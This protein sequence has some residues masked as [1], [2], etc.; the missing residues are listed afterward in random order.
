MTERISPELSLRLELLKCR[1]QQ[2]VLDRRYRQNDRKNRDF[3]DLYIT[4][5]DVLELLENKKRKTRK[6]DAYEYEKIDARGMELREKIK[7][8]PK[9]DS[10]FSLLRY[11]FGLSEQEAF[12]CLFISAPDL[13]PDFDIIVAFLQDNLHL[14]RPSVSL[15]TELFFDAEL[16][17]ASEIRHILG[18]KGTLCSKG[19]IY[20]DE[21]SV[22]D[23]LSFFN[24]RLI[25]SLSLID[26]WLNNILLSAN[27]DAFAELLAPKHT[28]FEG[29]YYKR[30]NR[31]LQCHEQTFNRISSN[32]QG[33]GFAFLLLG[34][35]GIGLEQLVQGAAWHFNRRVLKINMEYFATDLPRDFD[36]IMKEA[37][38]QAALWSSVLHFDF[39]KI[40]DERRVLILLQKIPRELF[41]TSLTT[42]Y[43]TAL[44]TSRP[45]WH[46]LSVILNIEQFDPPVGKERKELWKVTWTKQAGESLDDALFGELGARYQFTPEDISIAVSESLFD[47]AI[48]EHNKN[49]V[50]TRVCRQFKT[51]NLDH[52]A[53]RITC[54]YTWDDLIVPGDV[55]LQ[56]REICDAAKYTGKVYDDWGFEQKISMG[57]GLTTLFSGES[58]TGKTMS[59]EIIAGTLGLELYRID[60]SMMVSK[61]IGET[62]KNITGVFDEAK[63]CNCMLLFDEADAL[64]GKRSEVKDAHDRYANIEVDHLL[65]TLEM[66]E[67]IVILTTNFLQNLDPAFMRRIKYTVD[68]PFPDE[69]H[70]E[71]LWN[72]AIP[73]TAPKSP[74][75]DYT[76]LSKKFALTGASIKNIAINSAFL[77]ASNG[78]TIEMHHLIW[79]IKREYQ[80]MGKFPNRSEFGPYYELVKEVVGA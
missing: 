21:K 41:R 44:N 37:L 31:W 45:V 42:C 35:P 25:P 49:N 30:H 14:K 12:I 61:Y 59:A 27:L 72:R 8:C 69:V 10:L 5:Q 28:V 56:L 55:L 26:F 47:G 65:Q 79:A 71:R 67:G 52:L 29:A 4:E 70:R 75:I 9:E 1:L 63:K 62:E 38:S 19:L 40:E 48:N 77:A 17:H 43:F 18:P 22:K 50:L 80:K 34:Q 68:F 36:R 6:S 3:A 66:H 53:T 64:F 7:K 16:T 78:Q 20:T 24:H 2:A 60:L 11:N 51:H 33:N 13:D 23:N 32:S 15:V 57:K 46:S 39:L 54:K 74:R 76:F 73:E 58:G